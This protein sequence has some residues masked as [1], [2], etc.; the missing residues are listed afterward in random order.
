MKFLHS[1]IHFFVLKLVS[2]S[3]TTKKK[4]ALWTLFKYKKCLKNTEKDLEQFS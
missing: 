1:I 2:I 4:F 3:K